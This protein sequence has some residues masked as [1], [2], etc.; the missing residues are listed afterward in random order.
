MRK[1]TPAQSRETDAAESKASPAATI[2]F[3]A[4]QG[5]VLISSLDLYSRI[6]IGQI[7][8]ACQWWGERFRCEL[9]HSIKLR[10]T[11]FEPNTDW[12]IA[13]PNTPDRAKIAHDIQKVV[14]HRLAWDRNPEGDITVDFDPP[15]LL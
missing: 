9:I 14:R 1:N 12:G 15:D 2:S 5:G 6:L 7:A 10:L 8:E 4:R 13:N 3:T 11:G